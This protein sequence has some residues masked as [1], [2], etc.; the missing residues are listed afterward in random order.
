MFAPKT[1]MPTKRSVV[2]A[3]EA[4]P[5]GPQSSLHQRAA[6][7]DIKGTREALLKGESVDSVDQEARGCV[8]HA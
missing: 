3:E 8:C 1:R 6:S 4:A 5:G 7:G 2:V